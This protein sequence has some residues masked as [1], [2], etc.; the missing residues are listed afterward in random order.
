[1]RP[2]LLLDLKTRSCDKRPVRSVHLCLETLAGVLSSLV[3]LGEKPYFII[4]VSFT[5][6]FFSNQPSG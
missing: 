3:S 4:I 1:M 2:S 6:D 5:F